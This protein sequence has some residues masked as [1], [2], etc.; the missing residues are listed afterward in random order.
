LNF[1][2]LNYPNILSDKLE[3]D[4]HQKLIIKFQLKDKQ[5]EEFLRAQQAFLRLTNK[6][7]N[8]EVIYL[9]EATGGVNSQYKVEVVCETKRRN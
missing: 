2:R 3:I 1:L 4:Y 5:T 9:A 6:K 8:K 7:S